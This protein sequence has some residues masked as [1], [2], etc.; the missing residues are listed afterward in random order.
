MGLVEFNL[1][2]FS[3]VGLLGA[4]S[5]LDGKGFNL[6]YIQSR[7]QAAEDGTISVVYQNGDRC[8]NTGRYSTRIILQCDHNPVSAIV[9][10]RTESRESC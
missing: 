10:A 5:V 7:P 2:L 9:S 6:G 4:C 3:I 1:V 8:G